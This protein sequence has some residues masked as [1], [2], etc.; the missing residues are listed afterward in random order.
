MPSF[1]RT[2]S[3]PGYLPQVGRSSVYPRSCA[4]PV[5]EHPQ[6]RAPRLVLQQGVMFRGVQQPGERPRGAADT[7][8]PRFASPLLVIPARLQFPRE[9]WG[10]C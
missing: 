9:L 3:A 5:P 8:H 1:R 6:L 4:C 2:A 10:P 7:S